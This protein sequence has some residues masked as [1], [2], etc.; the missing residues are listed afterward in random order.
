MSKLLA[1]MIEKVVFDLEWDDTLR[2]VRSS[3]ETPTLEDYRKASAIIH[4]RVA[5]VF[6]D[7]PYWQYHTGVYH[8]VDADNKVIR[9]GSGKTQYLADIEADIVAGEN[10]G[11]SEEQIQKLHDAPQEGVEYPFRHVCQ[12]EVLSIIQG[13]VAQMAAQELLGDHAGDLIYGINGATYRTSGFVEHAALFQTVRAAVN[14]EADYFLAGVSDPSAHNLGKN[15]KRGLVPRDVF[16]T[17][18]DGPVTAKEF[19]DGKPVST[20]EHEINGAFVDV[21]YGT[22]L[23]LNGDVGID[24]LKKGPA[25]P[26][27]VS[28]A[29]KNHG[30]K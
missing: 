22:H 28:A 17:P 11:L 29:H 20:G 9:N 8:E 12:C 25:F 24:C 23:Y 7:N 19:E 18:E 16:I 26:L 21:T 15:Q 10:L 5:E 6:A 1:R 4:E 30:P 14:G 2:S 27:T 3:E 13:I